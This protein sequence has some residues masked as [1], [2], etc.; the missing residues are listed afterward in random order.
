[1]TANAPARLHN[2][3]SAPFLPTLI[4]A[5]TGGRLSAF[6]ACAIRS[7][8]PPRRSIC[9][10]GAPAGWR[11]T[12]FSMRSKTDAAILPRIVPL[13]DIDEDEIV[14][15]EAAAGDSRPMRSS[16]RRRSAAS[17][18]GCCWRSSFCK[19]ARAP[20]VR[21]AKARRSSRSTPAAALALADDLAR[22]MDDMTTRAGVVGAARRAGA[23][24]SRPL[25]AAHARISSRS[26]ASAGR[27]CCA[28]AAAI[29]PAARRDALIKAEAARLAARRRAG[30]RRRLDRLDAG[31]RRTDRHHRA[32]AARRRGA[33]RARH[34]S[35]RGGLAADRR[36]RATARRRRAGRPA[37]RNSPCRRC[38]RASASRATRSSSWRTTRAAASGS[39][40]KRCARPAATEHGAARADR[41]FAADADAAL[42]GITV[43]EAANAEDEALA[44]AVALREA[45]ESRTRPPR[46]SRPTARSRA[47]SMPRSR[48]G[49]SRPRF[50]RRGARRRRR[51]GISRGSRRE[52]ALGGLAPVTLLALAQASAA[53]AR[54]ARHGCTRAIAALERAVLRGPR[55]RAGSAGLAHALDA[56]GTQ[57][58]KY[59]ARKTPICIAPIR[60]RAFRRRAR[61]R[62]RTGRAARRGARAARRHRQR[63]RP[64][65]DLAARHR[66][67]LAALVARRRNERAFAGPRRHQAR[68]CAR[69]IAISEAAAGMADRAVATMSSCFAA[70]VA[71][72]VVRGRPRAGARV[73]ILGPLE[74]RLTDERSRGARRLGRRRMAAGKPHRRLAQPSDAARARARSARAPHR[75]FGARFRADAR[76]AA[77]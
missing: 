67:V 19:W 29:E 24:R 34:R 23:R 58:A 8:S 60:A 10:R 36:R 22:L 33:A 7:R 57:L 17:N 39:C 5:L 18:G 25:L 59:R 46:W 77:R 72:R 16:C 49:T 44:I 32:A 47:A 42:D 15:A 55:P 66:D 38:S 13:G 14:F 61:S 76:R 2:P 64:L 73:R 63:E 52:A 1:M 28:S 56:F 41:A 9:R 71:D 53:A 68:R 31:D 74:A 50:R 69:R 26:R 70:V 11:A 30:D 65:G 37:I 3:A 48:A 75:P 43:I 62:R 35:R 20:D 54:H 51:P 45:V 27:Q 6:P 4:D 40:R 12:L 21:G